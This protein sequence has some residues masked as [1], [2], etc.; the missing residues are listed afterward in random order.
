MS[1]AFSAPPREIPP[2]TFQLFQSM[3]SVLRNALD[4]V[5]KV[6]LLA[7]PYG[8]KKLGVVMLLS[9]AQGIFQVL[10]VTSIFP[11]L[12][13][14]SDPERLRNSRLGSQLLHWLPPFDNSQLLMLSGIVAIVMLLLSNAVN[15]LAEFVRTRY[16]HGFGHWLRV[17]LLRKIATRPYTEFLQMN[18][19]ILVK[20]VVSD[21]MQ[22]TS[23][24]L[25]LLLDCSARIV[26]IILLIITL[27]LVQPSI[28]IGATLVFGIYYA[29][30]FKVFGKWR[31]QTSEGLKEAQRGTFVEAQ[32]MLSGIKTMKVHRCEE[33]FISRFSKHSLNEARL[34]AWAGVV[35]HAP[36]YLVEPIALGSVVFVV[37]LY[38]GR[39]QDLSVI[40]PNLGVMALAGY[41]LL[42]ALQLVYSQLSQ[43]GT[44]LY[45]LDE[46]FDEYLA[47][48]SYLG[49]D[50]EGGS[51][52][53]E[54][55]TALRWNDS[56]TLENLTFRYPGTN[57]TV[58]EDLNLMVPKNSSLGIVGTTGCG[59]STLVDI[60]LG[61]HTPTAGRILIDTTVLDPTNRRA[62]RGGIGYVP[63]EIFLIDDTIIANIAL[64]VRE[65]EIDRN[66]LERAAKSAQ[67]L[68]FIDDLPSQWNTVVGE[69]GVR[70]SG[71]Q[72]QRIGLARALYHQPTLLV[73]DE[74]T[75]ALDSETEDGVMEAIATL[76]GQITMIIIAHRTRTVEGCD[77][78]I[79]L[80]KA[81]ANV[82]AEAVFQP[83]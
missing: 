12:A 1:S 50:A 27:F 72:R 9:L 78:R 8:R 47:A 17:G 14:S 45:A 68:S 31:Q 61:L 30:I 15:L 70:L 56:I 59:K 7:R 18:S 60:I 55:P 20:K 42:P 74:A 53:L 69:R 36:R 83:L 4:L 73:L 24:V 41:R 21:V 63:Q 10:G 62:W 6:Y 66:A 76:R 29:V 2:S 16:A 25:L 51:G 80:G 48:E 5:R 11:F 32:Q 46:V 13:L 57:K 37:M 3:P 33:R 54:A 22:F 35:G 79:D 28:A 26:T 67:I 38:V 39:G 81:P 65:D 52:H 82:R 64:G 49:K 19:G 43:L 77:R 75:S 44:N 71:G 34:L 40:L 58:I 23:G